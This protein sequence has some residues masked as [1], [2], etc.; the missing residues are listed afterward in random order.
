[1][2]RRDGEDAGLGVVMA[3]LVVLRGEKEEEEEEEEEEEIRPER[4][5]RC[6]MANGDDS[7]AV[8]MISGGINH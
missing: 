7:R 8:W 6:R 1:M 4:G 3:L 2:R 5:V